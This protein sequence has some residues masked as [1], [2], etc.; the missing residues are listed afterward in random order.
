MQNILKCYNSN[1]GWDL[2]NQHGMA[3]K[4]FSGSAPRFFVPYISFHN[5]SNNVYN[6]S[7]NVIYQRI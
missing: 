5:V 6:V 3:T 1:E 7:N 2:F 4:N